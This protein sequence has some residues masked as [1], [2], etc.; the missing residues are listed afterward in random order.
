MSFELKGKGIS[1]S[2]S[3]SGWPAVLQL[4][5]DY[6][7]Q[8]A[9]TLPPRRIKRDAWDRGYAS[10][11]GQLVSAD[12]A[13]ALADALERG[14]ADD[15]K[16]ATPRTAANS[17]Q[18][19]TEQDRQ[20]AFE[21]LSA[22]ANAMSFEIVSQPTKQAPKPKRGKLQEELTAG[23]TL[24]TTMAQQGIRPEDLPT[25]LASLYGNA[26]A[27]E[28]RRDWFTSEDGKK[29]VRDLV[30]FCRKGEFRIS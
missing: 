21:K 30:D 5:E 8:P 22:L 17:Q 13:K 9:G 12:D 28:T 10:C 2:W 15:F 1:V 20:E 11:D 24:E 19:S 23:A 29:L 16:R 18:P 14:L 3:N 7:W 6:G 26:P 25:L 27:Q 4:A